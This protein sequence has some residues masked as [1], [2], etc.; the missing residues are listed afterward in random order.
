MPMCPLSSASGEPP[1]GLIPIIRMALHKPLERLFGSCATRSKMSFHLG[2]DHHC[3][4]N[5]YNDVC[6][7]KIEIESTQG[8][9]FATSSVL[10]QR[11]QL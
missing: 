11:E 8:Q 10:I 1:V 4:A 5:E 3:F 6:S 2:T 9:L 7:L